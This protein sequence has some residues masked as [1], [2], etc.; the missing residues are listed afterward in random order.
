MSN[1]LIDLSALSEYKTRSDAKYQDKLTAGTGISISASNVISA[2]GGGV[3]LAWT[4]YKSCI[5]NETITLDNNF[6]SSHNE[7]MLCGWV[8]SNSDSTVYPFSV[9][10]PP[11]LKTHLPGNLAQT[12]CLPVNNTNTSNS[13]KQYVRL[14]IYTSQLKINFAPYNSEYSASIVN[15]NSKLYILTR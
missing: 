13:L 9:I 3:S 12:F 11:Y 6:W 4:F 14:V 5:G 8:G 15:S 1:K 2:T 10:I 7:V